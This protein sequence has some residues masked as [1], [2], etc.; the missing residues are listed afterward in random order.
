M[1]RYNGAKARVN[2]RLGSMVYESTGR[3]VLSSVESTRRECELASVGRP[4][5]DRP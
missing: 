3:F 2:R 5:T 4:T 1:A